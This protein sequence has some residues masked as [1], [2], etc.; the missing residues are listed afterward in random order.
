VHLEF[1][2]EQDEL[3]DGVR[4]MLARECP[5]ALVRE[6]VE[7]GSAPDTLW[8]QMVELGWPALTVPEYAGGLGMGTVELAVA[9]FV[10]VTA[11]KAARAAAIE[12]H[13]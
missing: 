1:T 13:A 8:A 7:K 12:A 10:D 5:I 2:A 6:V 9:A 11:E 4:T 3:R